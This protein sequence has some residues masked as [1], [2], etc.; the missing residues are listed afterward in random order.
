MFLFSFCGTLALGLLLL[1]LLNALP[2]PVAAVGSMIGVGLLLLAGIASSM[3]FVQSR[4]EQKAG[5]TTI[6][7]DESRRPYN[8]VDPATGLII[9]LAGDDPLTGPQSRR[10]RAQAKQ[11]ARE[12][13]ASGAPYHLPFGWIR[14]WKR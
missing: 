5:Y 10:A 6:W 13:R 11:H 3:F 8:E 4:R 14:P 1:M 7:A 9:R 2:R 12:L